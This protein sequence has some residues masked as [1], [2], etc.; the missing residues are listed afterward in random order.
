MIQNQ[1]QTFYSNNIDLNNVFVLVLVNQFR[2]N[3][4][5]QSC[6]TPMLIFGDVTNLLVLCIAPLYP[7]NVYDFAQKSVTVSS[8]NIFP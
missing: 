6:T 4:T 2:N 7:Q 3:G 1:K 8:G 5:F